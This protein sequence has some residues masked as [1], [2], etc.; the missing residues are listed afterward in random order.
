MRFSLS[1]QPGEITQWLDAMKMVAKLQ[2]GI[3]PEFRKRVSNLL[4]HKKMIPKGTLK[5]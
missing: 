4:L 1:P 2:G 3:P 5:I